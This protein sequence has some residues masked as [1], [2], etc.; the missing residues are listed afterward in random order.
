LTRGER[1]LLI[2]HEKH[3]R[4]YWLLPGGG[5]EHG[6][7][8]EQALRRELLE[9]CGLDG[10]RLHGP[11]AIAESIAPVGAA[12]EG[13][14]I[15]HLLYHGDLQGQQLERLQS[16]DV[17]VRNHR[18]VT[19]QDLGDT[20]LRP[21]IQRYLARYQPGDPFVSLGRVWAY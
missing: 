4:P 20:D 5:V 13:R 14:H 17:A 16:S 12:G 8:L 15:V 10:V 18:L 9:E 3:G 6:E 7:T 11:I 2:R 1:V 21:P 19:R